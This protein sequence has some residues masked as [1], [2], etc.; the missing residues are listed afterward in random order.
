MIS[1]HSVQSPVSTEVEPIYLET[2]IRL[3]D[4]MRDADKGSLINLAAAV[5]SNDTLPLE[6]LELAA[7]DAFEKSGRRMLSYQTPEGDP[8]LRHLLAERMKS[9]GCKVNHEHMI[10]TTG[11]T[12][13]LYLMVSLLAKPGDVIACVAPN[14]YALMELLGEAGAKILQLPSDPRTGILLDQAEKWIKRWRPKAL[15][16]CSTLSNPD[17]STMPLENRKELLEICKLQNVRIVEDD[18]YA[19]LAE[20]GAPPPIASLDDGSTVSYATSFSKSVAPGL[21]LGFLMPGDLFEAAASLKCQQDIHS[22]AVSQ[23]ML[24]HFMSRGL[25]DQHLERLRGIYTGRRRIAM[26]AIAEA[27]PKGTEVV[28]PR[29]G[30][31]LWLKLPRRIVLKEAQKRAL[32]KKI[33]FCPGDIFFAREPQESYMRV[34]CA[35]ASEEDLESSL[36]TLGGIVSS[37]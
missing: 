10:V 27:F 13:A 35:R 18:I 28:E 1:T 15:F 23:A 19:E 30:Y 14:Y 4:Y 25:L 21:R 32:E 24:R 12:Q 2:P 29:G 20:A 11:C 36:H 16:L 9:K 17:G 34:N 3:L 6:S 7:R 37:L 22:S 5:P 33:I 31:I 26:R 8:E